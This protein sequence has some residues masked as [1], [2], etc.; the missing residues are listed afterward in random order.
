MGEKFADD[1]KQFPSFSVYVPSN[2]VPEDALQ[3][4]LRVE[5][6]FSVSLPP[7]FADAAMKWDLSRLALG[8]IKFADDGDYARRVS[9]LNAATP[10]CE[11]WGDRDE[12]ESRPPDLLAI[13]GGDPFVILLNLETGAIY[14]H[15][16]DDGSAKT[17]LVAPQL[18]IFLRAVGTT[19]LLH[20]ETSKR[21]AYVGDLVAE[22]G[23]PESG[24]FWSE[25]AMLAE[26]Q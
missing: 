11:W 23:A 20:R 6:E 14:S 2:A 1:I 25:L 5:E 4:L 8:C 3:M 19:L 17:C 18:D 24:P 7:T 10:G 22:L 16:V 15:A 13:S 21:Q 26:E 9:K 12:W